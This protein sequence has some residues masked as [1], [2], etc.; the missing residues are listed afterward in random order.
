MAMTTTTSTSALRTALL[1]LG[2]A[3]A[4]AATLSPALAQP[5]GATAPGPGASGAE[6][7]RLQAEVA[8]LDKELREQKQ[9]LLQVMQADQQRYD[10]MLQ[11]VRSL[12]SGG[13]LGAGAALPALPAIPGAA[14]ASAGAGAAGSAVASAPAAPTSTTV[15]G[16]VSLPGGVKEAYVYVDG[17]GPRRARAIE[18]K[19]EAKQFSPQIAVVPAGSKVSFPN[20]D[21]VFHNVFS[22][23]PGTI[24]DLGSVKSG[25]RPQ[26]VTLTQPGHIEIFCNIHSKMRADVLVVPNSLFTKVKP[27]GSFAL[28]SVPAGSRKLVLWG[29]GLRPSSQVVEVRPGVTVSFAGEAAAPGAHMNKFGKSYGSY[30]D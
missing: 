26:P 30:G 29:P 22:R 12:Q 13:G 24:F 20:A 8:R 16:R 21:T 23:T 7:A 14:G 6:V 3:L 17:N 2:G 10:V 5:A 18:I 15:N 25:E 27:D 11:L 1:L 4:P 28:A 9:L 19:Q